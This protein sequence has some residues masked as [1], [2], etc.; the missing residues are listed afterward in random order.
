MFI[1]WLDLDEPG[2]APKSMLKCFGHS[3]YIWYVE[4]RGK[5]IYGPAAPL[6]HTGM[7]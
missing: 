1:E 5:G 3:S 2:N 6:I 7:N 4:R